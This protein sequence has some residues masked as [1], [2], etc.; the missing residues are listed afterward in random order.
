MKNGFLFLGL[1][2]AIQ[3]VGF[4]YYIMCMKDNDDKLDN[5]ETH[6]K[7][8]R[9]FLQLDSF[10]NLIKEETLIEEREKENILEELNTLSLKKKELNKLLSQIELIQTGIGK[11]RNNIDELNN[12]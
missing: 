12:R 9:D 2:T 11:I 5:E 1:F 3:T 8:G 6:F 4:V 7:E 10:E